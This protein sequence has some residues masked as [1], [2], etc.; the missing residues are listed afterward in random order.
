MRRALAGA[1]LVLLLGGCAAATYTWH[2]AD[3]TAE[4]TAR[5]DASCRAEAGDQTR[6]QIYPTAATPWTWSPWRRPYTGPYPVGA[7]KAAGEQQAYERCMRGR[8]YELRRSG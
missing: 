3:A 7:E 1:L 4:A 5:D 2:R 6:E 8:G